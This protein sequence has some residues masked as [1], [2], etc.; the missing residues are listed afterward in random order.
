MITIV[1]NNS[2][3]ADVEITCTEEY[4]RILAGTLNNAHKAHHLLSINVKEQTELTSQSP[5]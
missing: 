1:E 5:K 2:L 4:H 3:H